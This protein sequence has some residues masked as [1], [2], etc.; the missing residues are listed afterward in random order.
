MLD[1]EDQNIDAVVVATPDHCHARPRLQRYVAA[2]TSTARS[3]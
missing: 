1:K 2:S 3:P